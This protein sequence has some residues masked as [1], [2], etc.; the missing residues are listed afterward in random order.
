MAG[1]FKGKLATFTSCSTGCSSVGR[2]FC[3]MGIASPAVF[4]C[5]SLLLKE[6]EHIWFERTGKQGSCSI[7]DVVCTY[8]PF[9]DLESKFFK[10]TDEGATAVSVLLY[11]PAQ[12]PYLSCYMIGVL[13]TAA[14]GE[15]RRHKNQAR[16]KQNKPHKM[17][18]FNSKTQSSGLQPAS[19]NFAEMC[20]Y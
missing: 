10:K 15:Q 20:A 11:F 18:S 9:C 14:G 17:G 6:Q 3:L 8:L 2:A 4:L 19:S 16:S 7:G 13:H 12:F 1:G 5:V